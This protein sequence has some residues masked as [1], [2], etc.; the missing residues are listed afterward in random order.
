MAQPPGRK[1][2]D[3]RSA[4]AVGVAL[5]LAAIVV[6]FAVNVLRAQ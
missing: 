5:L 3:M 2:H 6:A 1:E 4:T